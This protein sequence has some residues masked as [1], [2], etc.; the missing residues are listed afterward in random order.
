MMLYMI[1]GF[2]RQLLKYCEEIKIAREACVPGLQNPSNAIKHPSNK[3]V[4]IMLVIA[5]CQYA[6]IFCPMKFYAC[7]FKDSNI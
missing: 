5:C 7:T 3:I 1:L 6:L 2:T 4:H